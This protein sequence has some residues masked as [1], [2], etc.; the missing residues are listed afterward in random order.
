VSRK[1][2]NEATYFGQVGSTYQR[3]SK[4]C[5]NPVQLIHYGTIPIKRQ[6]YIESF[7]SKR[8]IVSDICPDGDNTKSKVRISNEEEQKAQENNQ[9]RVRDSSLFGGRG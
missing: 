9:K 7:S 6:F 8:M 1:Y 5:V 4:V 2:S 3:E